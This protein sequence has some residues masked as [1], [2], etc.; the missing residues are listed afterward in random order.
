MQSHEATAGL[1]GNALVRLRAVGDTRIDEVFLREVARFDSPV[2]NTRRY[3]VRDCALGGCRLRRGDS[4]LVVLAAANRDPAVNPEPDCF[5]PSRVGAH[6][7]GWGLGTH[8]CPGVS[9][10]L[11]IAECAVSSLGAL[12]GSWNRLPAPSGYLPLS[13][14]RIPVFER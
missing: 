2:Q 5:R 1:I 4:V 7:Y 11:C 12:I 10:S 3:V 14:V 13:N 9:L 6:V 8:R